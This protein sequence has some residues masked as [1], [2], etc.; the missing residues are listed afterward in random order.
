MKGPGRVT[1]QRGA[2]PACVPAPHSPTDPIPG[3]R[4]AWAAGSA[5]KSGAT[6]SSEKLYSSAVVRTSHKNSPGP[7]DSLPPF[8]AC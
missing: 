5:D 7:R 8:G 2:E 6:G 3:A 4:A 1:S